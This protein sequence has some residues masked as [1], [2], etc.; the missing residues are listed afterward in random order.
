MRLPHQSS[1]TTVTQ[2]VILPRPRGDDWTFT[3]QPLSLGFHR[4]LRD[5]GITPPAPP[6]RVARD[7]SGRPL[8]DES[9][10]AVTTTDATDQQYL[11]QLERYHQRVAVLAVAESFQADTHVEFETSKPDDH[12]AADVWTTYADA[13]Y[14]ELEAAGFSA[15]DL[16]LLCNAICRLSNLISDHIDQARS[17]FSSPP[18]QD[19]R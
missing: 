5:R 10:L 2:T 6:T 8:R 14:A 12:A 17:N 9:G 7:S 13:L 18:T 3:I 11:D 1:P 15:G 16:I 4:R 19:S